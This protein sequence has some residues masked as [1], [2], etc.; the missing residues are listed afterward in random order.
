MCALSLGKKQ[1]DPS[2]GG[3]SP[4]VALKEERRKGGSEGGR[5]GECK[6]C[7]EHSPHSER[8]IA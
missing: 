4:R 2:C 7:S 3:G 6:I 1:L 8:G 5:E